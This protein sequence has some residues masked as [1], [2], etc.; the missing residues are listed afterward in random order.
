MRFVVVCMEVGVTVGGPCVWWK[1]VQTAKGVQLDT[2]MET[3][4]VGSK[5]VDVPLNV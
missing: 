2:V 5:G 3:V 4:L 1:R